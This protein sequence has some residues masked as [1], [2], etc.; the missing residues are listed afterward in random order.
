MAVHFNSFHSTTTGLRTAVAAFLSRTFGGPGILQLLNY[1]YWGL[2]Q[3]SAHEAASTNDGHLGYTGTL[4]L[5]FTSDAS[6][7]LRAL[8]SP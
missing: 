2:R 8:I 6:A 5:D 1:I 4:S 7:S 3:T